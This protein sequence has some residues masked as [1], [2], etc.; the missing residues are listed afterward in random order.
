M[1]DYI[2]QAG[3]GKPWDTDPTH[4]AFTRDKGTDLKALRTA[5]EKGG[6]DWWDIFN[7]DEGMAVVCGWVSGSSSPRALGKEKCLC[8]SMVP[9]VNPPPKLY[10]GLGYNRLRLGCSPDTNSTS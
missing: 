3:H 2:V 7:L 5:V 6:W 1:T 4:P 9:P 10:T 8:C